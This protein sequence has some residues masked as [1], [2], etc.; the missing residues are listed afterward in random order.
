MQPAPFEERIELILQNDDRYHRDSYYFV[1]EAL[2]HTQKAFLKASNT[3]AHH[4]T[5][6]QLLH[7]LREY[8]LQRFGPMTL[9]LLAEWGIRRTEDVGEIVYNM[10][11]CGL[12]AKTESDR[13]EDFRD[14]Y[15]F[16][17]VF[18]EP[19]KPSPPQSSLASQVKPTQV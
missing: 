1:R 2:D 14:G 17:K 15:D 4:V 11:D 16:H 6:Q 19:F 5:A 8:A 13:R 12:L 7:G 18:S 3:P 10:V 9:A